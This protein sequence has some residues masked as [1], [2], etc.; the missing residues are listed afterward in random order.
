MAN[1]DL[2][3][4]R[5]KIDIDSSGAKKGVDDAKKSVGDLEGNT[6]SMG[7]AAGTAGLALTGFGALAVGAFALAVKASAAFEK[8]LSEFKAVT[9]STAD[10]MDLIR[11]KALQLGADTAFSAK[12]AADAMVELGK[13]GLSVAQILDGAADATTSLAAAGGIELPEAAGIAAAAL[14]QFKLQAQDLPGVADLLAGAANASATGVSE[15]GHA[16][17]FVGPVAQAM[18]LSINDT[19]DALALLSNSG[20]DATK[21]GTALRAILSR[22]VPA[23]KQAASTMRE[24]GIVT[25]DGSNRFFDAQGNVKSMRDIIDILNSSTSKLTAEQKLQALQTIFGTEALAAAN[26]MAGTTGK[27]FDELAASIAKQKAAD[28]A[29]E[30]M[31]NLDG[32]LEQLSGSLDTVLIKAGSQFQVGLTKIVQVITNIVNAIGKLNPEIQKWI[33]FIVAGGGAAA[34][35]VGGILL[36]ISA[37][38]KFKVAFAAL[39]FVIANNPIV[40]VILIIAALVAAV[41]IAYNN[42]QVFHDAVD[43]LWQAVQPVW[44]NIKNAVVNL[45]AVIKSWAENT[46]IPAFNTVKNAVIDL[47]GTIRDW[48]G[49]RIGPVWD[50][51]KN[52]AIAA[53]QAIADFF[54]PKLAAIWGGIVAGAGTVI[55]WFQTTF[56]PG[57]QAVWAQITQGAVNA[58]PGIIAGLQA[59]WAG[60]QAGAQAVKDWFLNDFVPALSAFMTTTVQPAWQG[61]LDWING[62]FIPGVVAA[63]D[64]IK[65]AFASVGESINSAVTSGGETDFF[66]GLA[67]KIQTGLGAAITFLQTTVVPAIQGF[68]AVAIEQF[69]LFVGWVQTNFGPP[70]AAIGELFSAIFARIG[71]IISEA[72]ASAQVIIQ[73]FIGVAIGLWMLFGDTIINVATVLW[74]TVKGVIEGALQII[75]GIIN[76]ATAIISGDWGKAWEGIQNIAA[77]AWH[78]ITSIISGAIGIIVGIIQGL[79]SGIQNLISAAWN[80]VVSK[81]TETWNS[82]K[83]AVSNGINSAMEFIAGIGGRIRSALSGID[84]FGAGKAILDSLLSGLKSAWEAVQSFISGIAGW[85]KDHKGPPE[86]DAKLLKPAGELIMGGFI[87]ALQSG[88]SQVQ[89]L[90][91]SMSADIAPTF[92]GAGTG[93]GSVTN[94]NI[95][96]NGVTDAAGVRDV[97]NDPSFL[98]KITQAARAGSL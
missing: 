78:I 40:R 6:K 55:A 12:E 49:A 59:A 38:E 82:F 85:I 34:L 28:V 65:N 27:S 16:L 88:W 31:N 7:D 95:G 75:T 37:I 13:Q 24:L 83:E 30:R 70:I 51:L 43:N 5:G 18:G 2:G 89:G 44:D 45:A 66:T 80:F 9:G 57:I 17:S 20:I 50:V 73:I 41:V 36:L 84:L 97:V 33:G 8:S 76:I 46:V 98:R 71:P 32:A 61:F 62:T 77:G 22:L 81:T 54:G 21:G 15:L 69:G 58:A 96:I 3:T 23:S 11:E 86:K 67:E 93:G 53:G 87:N 29:A 35:A 19:V 60:I 47:A 4:A 42:V 25:A 39:N 68:V 1:Y 26:V 52:A 90:V 91:G 63:A 92:V 64:S 10:Q 48:I 94:I 56:I 74:N 79:A 72:L 14:N